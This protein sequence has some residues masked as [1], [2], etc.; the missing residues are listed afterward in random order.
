MA[1]EKD[2]DKTRTHYSNERTLLSYVRT[3]MSVL[4]LAVAM[5]RFFENRSVIYTGWVLLGAGIFILLL[6]AYRFWQEREHIKKY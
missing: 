1:S 2:L 6:G 3:S 4:V 5:M